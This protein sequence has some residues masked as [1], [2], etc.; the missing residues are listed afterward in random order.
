[1]IFSTEGNMES[2]T[3][4][5]HLITLG[6]KHGLDF[7]GSPILLVPAVRNIRHQKLLTRY[8]VLSSV[9]FWHVEKQ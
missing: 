7:V 5:V 3:K 2:A 9:D 6:A 8:W 4:A 1:M